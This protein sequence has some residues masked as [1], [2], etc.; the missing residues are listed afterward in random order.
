MHFVINENTNNKLLLI[1]L[2]GI[3]GGLTRWFLPYSLVA[4]PLVA[5]LRLD[6]INDYLHPDQ[7]DQRT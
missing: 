1:S 2:V 3:D 6:N 7:K 4:P 5:A